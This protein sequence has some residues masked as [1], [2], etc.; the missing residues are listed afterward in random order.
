GNPLP[1]RLNLNGT[2]TLG[3]M[4]G[5]NPLARVTLDL[6][7]SIVYVPPSLGNAF[8]GYLKNGYD[9]GKWDGV[10]TATTGVVLSSAA[11]GDQAHLSGIG[12]A[13]A[14][15]AYVQSQ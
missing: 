2:F 3:S 9:G 4:T 12:W 1:N 11:A 10:P 8:L 14:A 7:Q 5:T 6:R 15:D 13:N